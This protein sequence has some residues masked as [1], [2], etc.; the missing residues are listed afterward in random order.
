MLLQEFRGV[1]WRA[2]GDRTRAARSPEPYTKA[3]KGNPAGHRAARAG[4]TER[5]KLADRNEA[6]PNG[7]Q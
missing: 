3:L 4:R 6:G 5:T 2:E 1:R 7:K